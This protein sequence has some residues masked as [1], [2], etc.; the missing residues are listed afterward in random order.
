[1]A[2]RCSVSAARDGLRSHCARLGAAGRCR[3]RSHVLR[4]YPCVDV[5]RADRSG[6]D[7]QDGGPHLHLAC[8]CGSHLVPLPKC[9][10]HHPK[11]LEVCGSL[12][13]RCVLRFVRDSLLYVHTR[14][15]E[16]KENRLQKNRLSV[17]LPGW[18]VCSSHCPVTH[19]SSRINASS[20]HRWRQQRR[21]CTTSPRPTQGRPRP[22]QPPRAFLRAPTWTGPECRR[23]A[24]PPAPASPCPWR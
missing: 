2:N 7:R 17:D 16:R 18:V 6:C 4:C 5:E 21:R 9:N 13:V 20:W 24:G 14:Q 22:P 12:L 23:L 15:K 3:C 8:M 1:M 10:S 11:K 19:N